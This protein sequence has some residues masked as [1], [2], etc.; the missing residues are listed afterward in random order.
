MGKGK[1]MRSLIE[2]SQAIWESLRQ[3]PA[4]TPSWVLIPQ[5]RVDE[6]DNIDAALQANKHYFE[7]RMNE[8]YLTYQRQ[9][10]TQYDPMVLAISE[11]SYAGQRTAVPFVVGPTMM[12]KFGSEAPAGTL[13][14]CV[15]LVEHHYAGRDAR[16]VEEV[17][18]QISS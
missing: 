16:A 2:R 17:R 11:F 13:G 15:L 3:S 10:F 12:E 8:I 5:E 6:P 7:I 4:Q 9:W 1:D 14:V 18:G